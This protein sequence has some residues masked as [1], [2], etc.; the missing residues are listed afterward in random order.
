PAPQ[1]STPRSIS[2]GTRGARAWY[3]DAAA[4]CRAP[5]ALGEAAGWRWGRT[6]PRAD[7]RTETTPVTGGWWSAGMD[8][9]AGSAG[10]AVPPRSALPRTGG[11][12]RQRA[13]GRGA[14]KVP[15]AASLE[16]IAGSRRAGSAARRSLGS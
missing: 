16:A 12:A 14:G 10:R 1:P 4:L 5:L 13:G 9:R 7:F 6:A 11:G 15:R 2:Q 3:R 8:R